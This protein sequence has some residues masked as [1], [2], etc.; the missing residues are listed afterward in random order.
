MTVSVIFLFLFLF[1]LLHALLLLF[2]PE[3]AVQYLHEV[4]DGHVFVRSRTQGVFYPSVGLAADVH[5]KIAGGYLHDIRRGRLEAV[6]VGPVVEEQRQLDTGGIVAEY[7]LYP[8]VFGEDSGNDADPPAVAGS[9]GAR[10]ET[11]RRKDEQRRGE[12]CISF[13]DHLSDPENV[14]EFANHSQL[15][16]IIPLHPLFVN[17]NA[18]GSGTRIRGRDG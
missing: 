9:A 2:D 10:D 14:S 13:H 18:N 17:K 16:Y 15:Q 3:G 1:F 4:H 6:K 5:E 7:V 12:R 11:R 8:V